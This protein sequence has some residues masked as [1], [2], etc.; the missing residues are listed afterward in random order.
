[1]DDIV[2][3][4]KAR[5]KLWNTSNEKVCEV[6]VVDEAGLNA[7]SA[8]QYTKRRYSDFVAT[9]LPPIQSHRRASENPS[10][11]SPNVSAAPSPSKKAGIICTNTDLISLLSSLASS[12]TEINRC[13]DAT[14]T[15]TILASTTV[16]QPQ[17][18]TKSNFLKPELRSSLKKSNRSNSFDVSILKGVK[19]TN[20]DS[21]NASISTNTGPGWFT[22][23]HQPVSKRTGTGTAKSTAHATVTFAKET[24]EKLTDTNKESTATASTS[25]DTKATKPRKT[26]SPLSRLKWDGRSAIVD[27]RIIGSAIEGFLRR[28][29]SPS[30]SKNSKEH[31]DASRIKKSTKSGWFSKTEDED[32]SGDTCDSSSLCATLKDLFVK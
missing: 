10:M 12:A 29:S 22:K 11:L 8:M 7:S 30:S 19:L 26:K 16:Q 3:A 32:S 6:Q 18:P 15:P 25:K 28:D 20:E 14:T 4:R 2:Q 23:R 13:G 9:I 27:A 31:K 17:P 21:K 5:M 1:M 24:F